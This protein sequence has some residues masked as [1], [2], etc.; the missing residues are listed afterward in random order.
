MPHQKLEYAALDSSIGATMVLFS[1]I[2]FHNVSLLVS[3]LSQSASCR[4][5]RR[6]QYWRESHANMYVQAQIKCHPLSLNDWLSHSNMVRSQSGSFITRFSSRPWILT[7]P[8][9]RL[10]LY[11]EW[12]VL[13]SGVF[14]TT[15]VQ[16]QHCT[17]NPCGCLPSCVSPRENPVNE[18][19]FRSTCFFF[20]HSNIQYTADLMPRSFLNWHLKLYF[21]YFF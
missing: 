8:H 1:L 20:T 2:S 17:F 4:H 16:C 9:D 13:Y 18:D 15:A 14:G 10:R 12:D 21:L 7:K 19:C 11:L 6:A 5:K 3:R